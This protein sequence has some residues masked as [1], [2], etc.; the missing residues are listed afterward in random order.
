[1]VRIN[2]EEKA[3]EG[4]TVAAYLEAESFNTARIVV[5]RNGEIVPRERY[6]ATVLRAGDEVEVVCFMGGG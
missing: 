3:A 6:A 5:E 1:M 4:M 2:G